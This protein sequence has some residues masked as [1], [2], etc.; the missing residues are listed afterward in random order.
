MVFPT[1]ILCFDRYCT[2]TSI[3]NSIKRIPLLRTDPID[4]D[5]DQLAYGFYGRGA[6]FKLHWILTAELAVRVRAGEPNKTE[7]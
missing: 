1:R 6:L 4:D 7:V 3:E 2:R 5:D